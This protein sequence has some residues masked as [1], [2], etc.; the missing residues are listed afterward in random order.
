MIK[1]K[2]PAYSIGC[3]Y[4]D[5]SDEAGNKFPF[6]VKSVQFGIESTKNKWIYKRLYNKADVNRLID[7]LK[8]YSEGMMEW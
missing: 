6:P 7:Q 2:S 4:K 1:K 3:T 5:M 8:K